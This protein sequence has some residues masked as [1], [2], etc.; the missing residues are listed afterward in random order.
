MVRPP[1][2][3]E[4]LQDYGERLGIFNGTPEE[5]AKRARLRSRLNMMTGE[6]VLVAAVISFSAGGA[7]GMA[8]GA[9]MT[10]LRFRAEHAHKLPTTTTGW[11]LYHK[12]KNYQMSKGGMREGLRMGAKVSFWTT[13]MFAIE[14]VFDSYRGTK[15]IM[16]TT[17]ASMTVAGA[18]SLWSMPSLSLSRSA[19]RFE[20]LWLT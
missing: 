3:I 10:G 2:T 4:E 9:K 17:A 1:R 6:R 11:W 13:A 18:F 14:D 7:L 19:L 15:D 8:Q 5:Q 16:N 20:L 12:S